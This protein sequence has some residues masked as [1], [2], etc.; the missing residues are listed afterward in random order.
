MRVWK[1]GQKVAAQG[2]AIII[3]INDLTDA[4]RR[5]L[6]DPG[7]ERVVCDGGQ[8]I[9]AHSETGHHHV[10]DSPD[11]RLLE[12][13]DP[14]V[15]RLQLASDAELQHLRTFDTHESWMLPAGEYIVTRQR[16]RGPE[17]WKRV[18]D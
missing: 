9:V 3:R 2:E 12:T 5:G 7:G 11:V 1:P 6:P 15:C 8:A 17:G 13:S 14:L 18:E 4:E 10:I 16:E